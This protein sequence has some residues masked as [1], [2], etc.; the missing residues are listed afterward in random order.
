MAI[1]Y[2]RKKAATSISGSAIILRCGYENLNNQNEKITFL[3][4][5]WLDYLPKLE[6]LDVALSE[7]LAAVQADHGPAAGA[8]VGVVEGVLPSGH[9]VR[10]W[11]LNISNSLYDNSD[12]SWYSWHSTLRSSHAETRTWQQNIIVPGTEYLVHSLP[13]GVVYKN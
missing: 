3:T 10:G 4:K 8:H 9:G 13:E 12:E 6:V 2:K 1:R 7:E 11:Q 5:N